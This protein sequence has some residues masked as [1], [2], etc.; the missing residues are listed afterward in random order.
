MQAGF[1]VMQ[2]TLVYTATPV[3]RRPEAMGL[4]TMCIG[5]SP[6]G[7]LAVGALAERLGAPTR[8]WSAAS[9]GCSAWP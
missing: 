9:A 1:A 3:A 5:A 6:L 7:F 4:M 8:R 2:T